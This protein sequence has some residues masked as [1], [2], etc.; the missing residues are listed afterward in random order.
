MNDKEE[1]ET[2]HKHHHKSKINYTFHISPIGY[3]LDHAFVHALKSRYSLRKNKTFGNGLNTISEK[4][5]DKSRQFKR[6]SSN[7]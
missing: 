7:A 5:L 4:P 3:E 2:I 6:R 1:T